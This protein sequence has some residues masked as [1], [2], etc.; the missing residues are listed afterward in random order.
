[1]QSL[2][3]MIW[4]ACRT[5]DGPGFEPMISKASELIS[6]DGKESPEGIFC[7][8]SLKRRGVAGCARESP[9]SRRRRGPV[10]AGCVGAPFSGSL[11]LP[12]DLGFPE[13]I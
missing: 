3:L 2:T 1:M 12:F 4:G 11:G 8:G 6:F 9:A 13:A 7:N 5:L 10:C